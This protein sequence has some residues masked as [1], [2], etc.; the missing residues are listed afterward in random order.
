MAV[1]NLIKEFGLVLLVWNCYSI[2]SNLIEFKNYIYN[3]KP[4]I[5]CLTE[6]WL[7]LIDKFKIPGYKIYRKDRFGNGGGVSILICDSIKSRNHGTFSYYNDGVLETLVVQ[8]QFRNVWAD[9]CVM[10][11]PC[12]IVSQ[13]EFLFYFD[14]LS[15]NSIICGDQNAHHPMWAIDSDTRT[16]LNPT[17]TNLANAFMQNTNFS[18]LTP[19]GTPTYLNK[20]HSVQSTIDL[21]FGSG[22]FSY[23][24]LVHPED[25]LGGDH[26][27]ISYCFNYTPVKLNSSGP[28]TWNF[29]KLDWSEW[30]KKL[31]TNFSND[32]SEKDLLKVSQIIEDTTKECTNIGPKNIKPKQHKPFWTSECSYHIALRRKAQKK[33]ERFP[34]KE[35]KTAL[36]KQTAVV[37]RFMLTKKREKW[38]EFCNGLSYQVPV[39]R[40]WRF[41]RTLNGNPNFDSS[42]PLK[43]LQNH[44]VLDNLEIADSFADHY[45]GTFNSNHGVEDCERKSMELQIAVQL[46]SNVDYNSDFQ[47]HELKSAI[48]SI[49]TNSAMGVDLMHNRFF[50]NFP[51]D[52]LGELLAVINLSWRTANIPSQLKLSTLIP[53]LKVGKDA[54]KIES[55]RPISLLSCF[56]KLIEKLVY[57]RLYSFVENKSS[58]PI[59]QCGFRRNHSCVDV[60]TYL[61]HFIQLALRSKKVLLIVFFDIE[62]AFDNASHLQILY[63][64]LQIGIKGRMLKWLTDFFT[65][66]SSNVRIG[67]NFSE[68]FPMVN[69][70]PQG[71][72]LSPLLFSILMMDLPKYDLTHVLQ[73]ADDLSIFTVD[74]SIDSAVVRIQDSI[75]RLNTWLRGIG[76]NIN[77]SK[78]SFMIFTRKKLTRIPTLSLNNTDINF[79]TSFKFLGVFL[80]GPT[81]TWKQHVSYLVNKSTQSLNVMKSLA[82]TKWGAH[83]NM[84]IL[85]YQSYIR[86]RIIYAIQVYS[87]ASKSILSRLE[88]VQNSAIRIITGLRRS[89][90]IPAIQ[91]ESNLFPIELVIK[92]FVLRYYYRIFSLPSN[93][94]LKQ[95]FL[96]QRII[97][98][99]YSWETLSH[100]SPFLKRAL[101][102]CDEFELPL[103]WDNEEFSR[104][105]FPPWFDPKDFINTVF[106]Q[107]K[108]TDMGDEEVQQI[109]SFLNF[110]EFKDFVKIYTDGTKQS[111]GSVGAAIFVDDISATF[112]WRLDSNHSILSA[113]LFAIFQGIS[114]A[115]QHFKNQN[116]V[117]FTDSLSSLLGI[118][119][120][121]RKVFNKLICAILQQIY[122]Y[123]IR[124][125]KIVLQWIPSHKGI[126]GN[127]IVDQV[128]KTACSYGTITYLPFAY[129]DLVKLVSERINRARVDHWDLTKNSLHFYKAVPDLKRYEWISLNNRSYDVLLARFRSGCVDLNYFLFNIKKRDNPFCDH[130]LGEKE[131]VEHFVLQCQYYNAA[132][133][134]LINNLNSLDIN[135]INFD[136]QTLLT[137]GLFSNKIRIKILLFFIEF[138]KE[139]E[140]LDI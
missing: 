94:I 43:S 135:P 116:I 29:S 45:S 56:A 53:I 139:S 131:T 28:E 13:N 42:Y 113:E 119:N 75:S 103:N 64:L 92:M 107:M 51:I 36:N 17:G 41:F 39:S 125:V 67:C 62:K 82:S 40:V 55:Y 30:R 71:S 58:I 57:S 81:L 73:Y 106:I 66:R 12:K 5:I 122:F 15:D 16:Y 88:I 97:I 60:L 38:Q 84:L 128:A 132:R 48:E 91:F 49:N 20:K 27:P 3:N 134:N 111:N 14:N 114:F 86:S 104:F 68:C 105:V 99:S 76:L 140:R 115:S 19:P 95:L 22:I 10:Y 46:T 85:F 65:N 34:S 121:A 9:I 127:N 130:C 59:F 120:P 109:F 112:S 83:R 90:P 47:I 63:N 79:V 31:V 93:H 8:V 69:G 7:K 102:L 117:I 136:L 61:E 77:E 4:H 18:L 33:Y 118:Q 44:Q 110:A 2:N 70:V 26:Y 24:D 54:T 78:T 100:K 52:L 101:S 32:K 137:G 108:K 50:S 124:N 138:I 23:C 74:D 37:K 87:S 72:I 129:N 11:N 123:M 98:D 133:S 80:D 126:V 89:T 6:T 35:N 21:V 1:G 25:M 96:D